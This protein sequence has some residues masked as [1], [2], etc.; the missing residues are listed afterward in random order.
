MVYS[1]YLEGVFSRGLGPK[2]QTR[3]PPSVL[4][5]PIDDDD[6]DDDAAR[7]F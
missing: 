5:S 7:F 6:G 2:V 3:L 4:R 1:W